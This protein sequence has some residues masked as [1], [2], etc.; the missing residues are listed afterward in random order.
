MVEDQINFSF[1]TLPLLIVAGNR[2]VLD[3]RAQGDLLAAKNYKVFD[4]RT[5]SVSW[6]RSNAFAP[7]PRIMS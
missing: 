1:E 5:S 4:P 3:N 2:E 7:S 6:E